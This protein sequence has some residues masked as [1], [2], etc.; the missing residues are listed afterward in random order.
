MAT[1]YKL[2]ID[3]K[4]S[5]DVEF[6]MEK[7]NK[8]DEKRLYLEGIY[9]KHSEKNQNGRVYN[10]EEMAMQ[11]ESWTNSHIR[12]GRSLGELNHPNSTDVNP[13]R[14][15]H[16]IVEL[17][18]GNAN[19][20]IGKSLVLTNTPTG[21]LVEGLYRDGCQL[22]MSTRALG[23]VTEDQR[24][25]NVVTDF[26]LIT[27]DAV[28]EPSVSDAFVNSI[29]ENKS[30]IIDE[31]GNPHESNQNALDKLNQAVET[32]P[33]NGEARQKYLAEQVASFVKSL[34]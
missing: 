27:V 11:V 3:Q 5:F 7:F 34:V 18:A 6:I 17:K 12:T 15:C 13:E 10:K 29:L 24:G 30:F 2:I 33:N 14:A 19:T 20:Y 32:L 4:P 25:N 23:Q 8:D 21:K 9:M 28:N 26:R 16:R 31:H 1:P 22:G